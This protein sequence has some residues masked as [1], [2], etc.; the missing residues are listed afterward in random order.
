M[1]EPSDLPQLISTD[2]TGRGTETF[3]Y[4]EPKPYY[5]YIR[6]LYYDFLD[7]PGTLIY[8]PENGADQ[9]IHHTSAAD[10]KGTLRMPHHGYVTVSAYGRWQ[11]SVR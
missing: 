3:G 7:Y 1:V 5:E 6:V 8:T 10:Q 9:V 2:V 4:S 11:L